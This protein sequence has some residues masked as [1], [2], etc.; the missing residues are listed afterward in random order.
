MSMDDLK[1][2]TEAL[3]GGKRTVLFDDVG[4]PSFYNI[5]PKMT[6]S[7]LGMTGNAVHPAFLVNEQEIAQFYFSTYQNIIVNGRAHSL[8]RK[9][10]A[11]SQTHDAYRLACEKKGKGFHLASNAE[12]AL[13]SLFCR[14]NGT[15]PRGNTYYGSDV[16]ARYEKGQAAILDNGKVARILTGTGPETWNHDHTAHGIADMTGNVWERLSGLRLLNGEINIIPNNNSAASVDESRNS[17]NW[18]AIMPDGTLVAPGTAGALKIDGKTAGSAETVSKLV[19]GGLVLNTEVRYPQYTGGNTDNHYGYYQI[20]FQDFATLNNSIAVPDLLK[21]L[22]V[23]PIDAN[24][25]DDY[26]YVRNY[27]ERLP[28]RGGNWESSL[29]AGLFS[30]F[31]NFHRS[32][33]GNLTGFRSAFVDL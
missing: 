4:Y 18:R 13:I 23:F 1:L 5:L 33:T 15:I 14:A 17:A 26:L 16:S 12:W 22:C 20:K 11:V 27:G 21:A 2:A 9:D 6:Y 19:G 8:P 3:S 24:H 30:L 10:P 28:L 32:I 7:D 31:L 25:N 29:G